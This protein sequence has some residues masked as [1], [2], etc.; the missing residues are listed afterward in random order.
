MTWPVTNPAS[1]EARNATT[2]AVSVGSPIRPRANAELA[3][4]F[5]FGCYLSERTGHRAARPHRVDRDPAGRELNRCDPG[6]LIQEGLRPEY[7]AMPAT[8]VLVTPEEMF[9]TRPPSASAPDAA[10]IIRN[11]ARASTATRRS[12][13]STEVCATDP[14]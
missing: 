3:A 9:T 11:G 4:V 13:S 6:D 7:S 14:Q 1:S 5:C 12:K 8:A 10:R 2:P